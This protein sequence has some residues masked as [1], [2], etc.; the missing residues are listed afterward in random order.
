MFSWLL[1][2]HLHRPLKSLLDGHMSSYDIPSQAYIQFAA[3]TNPVLNFG[4]QGVVGLGFTGLSHID[5]TVTAS[6]ADWGRSLLYN[7]FLIYPEDPNFIAMSLERD[8]DSA[9]TVIGSLGVGEVVEEYQ[10]I[11]STNKIPLYPPSGSTRWTVLVDSIAVDG[12]DITFD[13]VISSVPDGRV[14]ALLDSGTTYSYAPPEVAQAIYGGVEGAVLNEITNQW[15]VPCSA[16][17]RL[18]IWIEYVLLLSP[19]HSY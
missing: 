14:V 18:T 1:S 10:D 11:M 5:S 7:I 15:E 13:S 17:I 19:W 12:A 8:L 4:A 16:G 3:G 6:G 2:N 9:N